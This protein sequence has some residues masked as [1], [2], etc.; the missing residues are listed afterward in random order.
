MASASS[1]AGNASGDGSPP[2]NEITPGRP[3]T[4]STSRMAEERIL[5]AARLRLISTGGWTVTT[6]LWH[7]WPMSNRATSARVARSWATTGLVDQLGDDWATGGGPLFRRLAR[8]ISGG[9]ERGAFARGERLPAE[10][11]LAA[12]LTVS[13]GTAVAAYDQLVADGLVER[14]RGSGT[15]VLGWDALGLPEGREGSGLVHRLVD[16]S[17]GPSEVVDLSISV[18][19]DAAALP[20]AKVTTDDL[21]G[22]V[23]DTGLSPWGLP[24]LR[25]A[26]AEHVTG[27]GLPTRESQIVITTGAQQAIGAAASCWLRPGD[28]VLVEDPTYPG[29]L[30]AFAQAGARIVGVPVDEN[31]VRPDALADALGRRPSLVYLQPTLHSPT[32]AV[33]SDARRHQ[34]GELLRDARVPL[35][36]DMALADLAWTRTPLPIAALVPGATV[37][38]IG[39]LSKLFWGGLRVGFVRA[40]E[41]LALRFAR[42]RTMQDLGTSA[43]SQLLAERLLA[44]ARGSDFRARQQRR[45]MPGTRRWPTPSA[46]SCR[47]G[48]GPSPR[49]D[50]RYGPGCPP[51]GPRASPTWPCGT[52]WRSPPHRPSRPR[53]PIPIG[54]ASPSVPRS[55]SWRKVCAVWARRGAPSPPIDRSPSGAGGA[56]QHA[57]QDRHHG[58]HRARD[59]DDDGGPRQVTAP[60]GH[61]SLGDDD[62]P[63]E[64]QRGQHEEQRHSRGNHRVPPDIRRAP[65]VADHGL[66]HN[67]RDRRS[68]EHAEQGEGEGGDGRRFDG[69]QRCRRPPP[70]FHQVEPVVRSRSRSR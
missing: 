32:G 12:A 62:P 11:A 13:R 3:A 48:A 10:R 56:A 16:R 50:C 21:I 70:R 6:R 54:S 37:A 40:P 33:L 51:P 14:R 69:Q 49:G 36:E 22:V 35:V 65:R 61:V 63:A 5:P 19:C 34:V 30:S 28:T 59:R 29:A 18:L 39:S 43:V 53:P 24:S 2:A 57:G 31:G 55:Q 64:Q 27:W 7:N 17:A 1:R 20:S 9:V 38:V 60:R 67:R 68:P 15:F 45:C 25:A 41:P 44:A 58:E 26:V 47:T 46:E 42:V 66:G 23:P 8:A 52:G 4:A